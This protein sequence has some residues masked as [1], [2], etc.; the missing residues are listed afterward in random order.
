MGYEY[1]NK[2][3]LLPLLVLA[4]ASMYVFGGE[5][6]MQ[7]EIQNRQ[8][9]FGQYLQEVKQTNRTPKKVFV[10]GVYASAVHAEWYSSDGRMICRALAVASEPAIFW[11]G[12]REEAEI[13][14]SNIKIPEGLGYL[15]P[16]DNQFNGP[17]GRALDEKILEPLGY[18]RDDAW[19]CDLVPYSC[20]NNNQRDA[21][22]KSYVPIQAEFGL[23]VCSIPQVP[24]ILTDENRRNEIL[25]ELIESQ[26]DTIILLGDEPI[27]WFLN[28]CSDCKVQKL[29]DFD[30]YGSRIKTTISEREYDV[31]PLAHPRQI[32]ALGKSSQ[33]W[34]VLHQQW[35]GDTKKNKG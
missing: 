28:Y 9:P 26:A 35:I 20:Q 31:I 18:S 27:K 14:I 12:S 13:I 1:Y 5:N 30:T 25:Q 21:L 15:R 32:A 29:S 6:I 34:Y 19:L 4:A 22:D 7:N 2:Y 33:K 8:F 16:A 24:K 11:R 3:I 10:L 23:P 17:S